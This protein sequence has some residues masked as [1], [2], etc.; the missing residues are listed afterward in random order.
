MLNERHVEAGSSPEA[1]EYTS[2]DDMKHGIGWF[3]VRDGDRL[4]H[5]HSGGGPGFAAFMRLY[6]D[7]DLGIVILANGTNVK[8]DDIADA[9]ATIE[10]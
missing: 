4:H 6:A 1:E 5:S 9:I 7:D 10:W 8:Y 2:Y 3:V